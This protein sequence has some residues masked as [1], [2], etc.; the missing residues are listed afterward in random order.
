MASSLTIQV[1]AVTG[2][3]TFNLADAKVA[4]TLRRFAVARGI[5]VGSLSNQQLA[6][7][8]ASEIA[9]MVR[10]VAISQQIADEQTAQLVALAAGAAANNAL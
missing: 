10:Q 9:E 4:D 2:V 8:V 5:A 3:R 7:A 6:N 1:G